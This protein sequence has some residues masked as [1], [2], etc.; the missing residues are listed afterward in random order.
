MSRIRERARPRINP[1]A[2]RSQLGRALRSVGDEVV[3]IT[4]RAPPVVRRGRRDGRLAS[5]ARQQYCGHLPSVNKQKQVK[6]GIIFDEW[7]YSRKD[8]TTHVFFMI[9]S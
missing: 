5:R 4:L 7:E 6:L 1:C 3:N 8:S 9:S 2:P